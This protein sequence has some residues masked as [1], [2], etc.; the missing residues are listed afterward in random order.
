MPS[1]CAAG[2]FGEG[3]ALAGRA[4]R[5]DGDNIAP[6][7]PHDELYVRGRDAAG[8]HGHLAS[9]RTTRGRRVQGADRRRGAESIEAARES[10]GWACA[11]AEEAEYT[12]RAGDFKSGAGPTAALGPRSTREA[13]RRLRRGRPPSA[14]V[15]ET[16]ELTAF[17]RATS[18][19]GAHGTLQAGRGS[20]R[21]HAQL[22]SIGILGLS[23]LIT[24]GSSAREHRCASCG[25]L[26]ADAGPLP[27]CGHE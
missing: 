15:R 27:P 2:T 14:S 9:R 17:R 6:E 13:R 18:A 16:C 8:P 10:G 24:A 3:G 5:G 25:T 22:G 26:N 4:G 12:G 11:T 7:L 1:G 21:P 23:A 20:C 19:A